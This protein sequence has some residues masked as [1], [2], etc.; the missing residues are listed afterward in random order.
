MR[1][2]C[3]VTVVLGYS[4][5][6]G[7]IGRARP[8]SLRLQGFLLAR[9]HQSTSCPVPTPPAKSVSAPVATTGHES[10]T[11][12]WPRWG[13]SPRSYAIRSAGWTPASGPVRMPVT[14]L[15]SG[16]VLRCFDALTSVSIN[17]VVCLRPTGTLA[18]PSRRLLWPRSV[19]QR[20]R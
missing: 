19:S 8:H 10:P 13:P 15:R 14:C 3:Y 20:Y 5:R 16:L 9:T 12:C 18:A 4:T 11:R 2:P 1:E 17:S 6:C 7:T